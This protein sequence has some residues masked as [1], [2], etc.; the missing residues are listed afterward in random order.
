M[1]RKGKVNGAKF[2]G[3]KIIVRRGKRLVFTEN[4]KNVS[5]LNEFNS[6]ARK[7]E[8]EH[9]A[10]SVALM[11]ETLDVTIDENLAGSV[12]R[13]SLER[14]DEEISGRADGIAAKPTE[15]ELREFRGILAARLPTVEQQRE[16]R[17]TV[18][19]RIDAIEA[20]ETRWREEAERRADPRKKLLYESIADVAALKADE[21]R[22]RA[23][24]RRGGRGR[25]QRPDV[26]RKV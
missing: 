26:V 12:L 11:E 24:V 8:E 17:I 10:T 25:E 6:L 4:V 13:S 16:G 2:D 20:E 21:L 19:D 1:N 5:K 9:S 3:V 23:N 15:N 22:L 7:A 14:L 18:E